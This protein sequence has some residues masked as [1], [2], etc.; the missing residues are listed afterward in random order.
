LHSNR[1]RTSPQNGLLKGEACWRFGKALLAHGANYLQGVPALEHSAD[2]Q[3]AIQAISGQT[4]ACDYFFI[5]AG[6]TNR[7][8]PGQWVVGFVER[9]LGR[10]VSPAEAKQL[11]IQA[12]T[13][14]QDR[15]PTLTPRLLDHCIWESER[16]A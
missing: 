1:Q 16:D 4:N 11:L 3:H 8:N 15:Y 6:A 7:V 12:C 14:L 10:A 13:Q 2:F 5:C 9:S